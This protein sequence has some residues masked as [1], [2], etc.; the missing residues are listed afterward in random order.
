VPF[1]LWSEVPACYPCD[2][3]FAIID[4]GVILLLLGQDC[5]L[6]NDRMCKERRTYPGISLSLRHH[7]SYRP[8]LCSQLAIAPNNLLALTVRINEKQV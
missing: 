7:L 6:L 2:V 3:L 8:Y 4:I 1:L 5:H